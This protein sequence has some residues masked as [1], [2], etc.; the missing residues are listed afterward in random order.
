MNNNIRN[1]EYIRFSR[2]SFWIG[3]F[4]VMPL[5]LSRVYSKEIDLGI[6]LTF[7]FYLYVLVGNYILGY[8][9]YNPPTWVK[10]IMPFKWILEWRFL[11]E[12]DARA[13]NVR[14]NK[15]N[16]IRIGGGVILLTILILAIM[17]GKV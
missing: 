12:S 15:K 1:P 5:F 17:S 16:L 13:A 2:V 11:S 6:I 8:R 4:I 10:W 14:T 7:F 9:L 3:I